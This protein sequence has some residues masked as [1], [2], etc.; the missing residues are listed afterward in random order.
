MTE[1]TERQKRIIM[2]L[3]NSTTSITGKELCQT[4]NISMR[5]VQS[6]ISTI[7]KAKKIIKST[8][9]GYSLIN[10]MDYDKI[11]LF[12]A[13][14]NDEHLILN[15]L[16]INDHSFQIDEFADDLYMSRTS[17][18]TKLKKCNQYLKKY[19]L[20]IKK[21]KNHIF[22]VGNESN[23]RLCIKDLLIKESIPAFVNIQNLEK[24][25]KD[26]N[27]TKAETIIL[28]TIKKYNYSIEEPYRTNVIINM[29][30][31]LHRMK[32]NHYVEKS[33]KKIPCQ[34]ETYLIAKEICDI[35]S[36][37]WIIY[38]TE[39][40]ITYM[41]ALLIGQIKPIS[42]NTLTDSHE[43]IVSTQFIKTIEQILKTVLN[44][45]SLN[46]DFTNYLYGFSLHVD[47][48]IK[49]LKTTHCINNEL[50]DNIKKNCPFIYDVSVKTAHLIEKHFQ[51]SIPDDEIGYICIHMGFLIESTIDNTKKLKICLYGTQ[52][53]QI[54]NR[55][56][57]KIKNEYKN[58]IELTTIDNDNI[59]TLLQESWDIIITTQPLEILGRKIIT[60]SPFYTL[61]DQTAINLAIKNCIAIHEKKKQTSLFS[62]Y[63]H[64]ELWF[65]KDVNLKKEE[66]IHFL[67]K[68]LIDSGYVNDDFINS[69]F[70]RERL[71]ST[72]FYGNFAIPH[73]LEMNAKKTM[74]CVLINKKEIQWDNKAIHIVLMIAVHEQDRDKFME[75]YNGIVKVLKYQ[76]NISSLIETNS[77]ESFIYSLSS[78]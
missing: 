44:S 29:I 77:F 63:F 32:S 51:L 54:L 30:I 41:N 7:N 22:I 73:A 40:D 5:T 58:Y 37:H 66:V 18:E 68:K 49:R 53:H 14:L 34:T 4:L 10:N 72:C 74:V 3:Y 75:L 33:Q 71:S 62:K 1:L 56:Q 11:E 23:K 42:V 65:K 45:Y 59:D 69:V 25:F 61:E 76:K 57:D 24:F 64:K 2:M 48:M 70:E 8:N 20:F 17:L 60:I 9:K 35:Y 27:I 28:S 78:K 16:L 52:Y 38:P 21:E 55:I 6:E 36:N 12:H 46:I 15:H 67:A 26:I 13:Q 43:N 19:D 39:E 47:S 50:I 31:A